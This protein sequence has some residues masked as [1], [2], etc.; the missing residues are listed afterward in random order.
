MWR[1]Y[2][3]PDPH[4]GTEFERCTHSTINIQILYTIRSCLF[5]R[6]RKN[7]VEQEN[8]N[9]KYNFNQFQVK[10]KNL[11]EQ[12]TELSEKMVE[13]EQ[14]LFDANAEIVHKNTETRHM[15]KRIKDL[16]T[17]NNQLRK[18]NAEV[19]KEKDNALTR[20]NNERFLSLKLCRN[21]KRKLVSIFCMFFCRLSKVAG[22]KLT[23][24]NAAITDLSDTN[25]PTKLAEKFSELYDNQWTD[26][27][28]E[29][30]STFN[31]EEETIQVLLKILQVIIFFII[32]S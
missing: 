30:D 12:C 22:A 31:N 8:Q 3:N 20:Y 10:N 5:F 1:I 27:Y 4:G 29:L 23:Q 2:S 32:Q 21:G 18:D 25:R 17:E 6:C 11:E 13:I 19:L 15:E 24:G 14:K 28:E 9:L 16:V 26:A 7:E